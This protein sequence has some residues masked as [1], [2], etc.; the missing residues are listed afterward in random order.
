M[1]S[2]FSFFV[3]SFFLP[4]IIFLIKHTFKKSYI[5]TIIIMFINFHFFILPF[6]HSFVT[7]CSFGHY[8]GNINTRNSYI[9]I[10]SK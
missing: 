5:I 7:I 4:S 1:F 6:L 9:E 2:S 3:T 10:L 8:Y